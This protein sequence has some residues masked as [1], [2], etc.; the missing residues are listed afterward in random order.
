MESAR[1]RMAPMFVECHHNV[2]GWDPCAYADGRKQDRPS[3]VGSHPLELHWP[4]EG[5]DEVASEQSR[6]VNLQHSLC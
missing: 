3:A 5:K 1:T 4:L 2:A 6:W